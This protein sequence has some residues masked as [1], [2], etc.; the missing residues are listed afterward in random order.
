MGFMKRAKALLDPTADGPSPTETKEDVDDGL[1]QKCVEDFEVSAEANSDGYRLSAKDRDYHDGFQWTDKEKKDLEDRGQAAITNNRIERKVDYIRGTEMRQRVDPYAYPVTH[2]YDGDSEAATDALRSLSD[3]ERFD[4][5]RSDVFD[6]LCVEGTG[7]AM[8]DVE[9]FRDKRFIRIKHIPWEYLAWDYRS[10]R[11]DF[12]DARWIAAATWMDLDEAKALYPDAKDV[13]EESVGHSP[14]GIHDDYAKKP[15][16]WARADHNEVRLIHRFWRMKGDWYEGIFA[17]SGWVVKPAKTK[18]L[19]D[20]GRTFCR[21][22]MQSVRVTRATEDR[23]AQRKG[24]VRTLISPQDSINKRES[25][26]MHSLTQNQIHMEEGSLLMTPEEALLEVAKPDG[27]LVYAARAMAEG[28]VRIDRNSELSQGQAQ[29]LQQAQMAVDMVGPTSPV[30]GADD[31]VRSGAAELARQEAGTAEVEPL[32]D[33]L[34]R[35]Q[36]RMYEG[37]WWCIRLFW[38]D[39]QWLR[40]TDDKERKG[41]RYVAVNRPMTRRQR[42][43]ELMRKRVPMVEAVQSIGLAPVV[44]L[45]LYEDASQF[46]QQQIQQQMMMAQQQGVEVTEPQIQQAMEQMVQQ[47]LLQ[48]PSMH[49]QFKVNDLAKLRTNI[50]IDTTPDTAVIAQA[51]FMKMAEMARSGVAIPPDAVVASSQL[52]NKKEILERMNPPPDPI[53]QQVQQIE[54]ELQKA[55]VEEVKA[56]AMEKQAHAQERMANAQFKMEVQSQKTTADAMKSAAEAGSLST[57]MPGPGEPQ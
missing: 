15:Q 30:M 35:W 33:A 13:L 43:L 49:E 1:H 29:A 2:M 57:P 25:K 10:T 28:K 42:F 12:S 16:M 3:Q 17:V 41:Y 7:G 46:A 47:L 40:V 14:D 36:T 48:H 50:V 4:W 39:E 11:A 24:L 23:P 54:M 52:R 22:I 5:T 6:N 19:D 20:Y 18:F 27:V 21:L 55:K 44:A 37:M 51:E 9:K 34:R 53:M 32:F 38:P 56:S 8:L 31:R 45:E 26:Q